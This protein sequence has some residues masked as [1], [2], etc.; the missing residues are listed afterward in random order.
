MRYP[1]QIEEAGFEDLL[2]IIKAETFEYKRKAMNC[3][4]ISLNEDMQ[5]LLSEA[6][7]NRFIAISNSITFP[8]KDVDYDIV[9]LF[10]LDNPIDELGR[11]MQCWITLG[12]AVE[13][14]LQIFL[15][16]YLSDF[17]MSGWHI[18]DNV[19]FDEVKNKLFEVINIM[20]ENGEIDKK[21]ARSLKDMIK[22]ELKSRA[23]LPKLDTI[24]LFDLIEFYMKTV[25]WDEEK[26]QKLTTIREYRNCIH[27]FKERD[28]RKWYELLDSIK[29]FCCL[30][31]DLQSMMPDADS[32]ISDMKSNMDY[33]Y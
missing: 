15:S 8:L 18:W 19:N 3:A 10:G 2:S 13:A 20:E 14:A 12:S 4:V 29:F 21:Q 22:K 27:S 7:L 23:T 17:E 11:L 6:S 28:L 9:S 24:M 26:I 30:I 31:L 16:V 32:I 25:N 5:N 33:Y 1:K